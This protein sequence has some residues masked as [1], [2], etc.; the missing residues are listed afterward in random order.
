MVLREALLGRQKLF[1]VVLYEQRECCKLDFIEVRR[2]H[3]GDFSSVIATV[4][5]LLCFLSLYSIGCQEAT[6]R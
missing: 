6:S 5:K 1:R 3:M 4:L 2:H